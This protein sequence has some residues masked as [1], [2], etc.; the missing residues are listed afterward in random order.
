[1][2]IKARRAATRRKR[3]RRQNKLNNPSANT[4]T[5]G[6]PQQ[7]SN[8]TVF[9]KLRDAWFPLSVVLALIG[10][11]SAASALRPDVQFDFNGMRNP[12]NPFSSRFI[13]NNNSHLA[14]TDVKT[15]CYFASVKLENDLSFEKS[16]AVEPV[17]FEEIERKDKVETRCADPR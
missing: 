14:L 8:K 9:E 7:K 5:A 15:Y 10:L 13:I 3:E 6:Q 1:M 16:F 2:G 17:K 11:A 12:A 4:Q